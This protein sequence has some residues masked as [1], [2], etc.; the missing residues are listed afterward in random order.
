M[1]CDGILVNRSLESRFRDSSL[2]AILQS[3]YFYYIFING[4]LQKVMH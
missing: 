4:L 3:A 2:V 1:V